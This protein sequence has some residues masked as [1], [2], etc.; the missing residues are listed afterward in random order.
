MKTFQK[1]IKGG[2]TVIDSGLRVLLKMA[3]GDVYN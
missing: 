1:P 2:F 3:N